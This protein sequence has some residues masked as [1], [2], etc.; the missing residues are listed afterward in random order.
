MKE[1][2]CKRSR[3][4]TLNLDVDSN[5]NIFLE[6]HHIVLTKHNDGV[7]RS[8]NKKLKIKNVLFDS[9]DI[10]DCMKIVIHND[11]IEIF[12]QGNNAN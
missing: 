11:K 10:K 3:E 2:F 1:I 7:L 5:Y 8:L 9:T 12:N 6:K 4:F